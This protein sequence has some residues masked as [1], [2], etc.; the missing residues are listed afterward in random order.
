MNHPSEYSEPTDGEAIEA[1]VDSGEYDYD[2]V[3][4]CAAAGTHL[5]SVDDDGYCNVCGFQDTATAVP[6]WVNEGAPLLVH[7][8]PVPKPPIR[9][10]DHPLVGFTF[11]VVAAIVI[12]W[13]LFHWIFQTGA[14][15]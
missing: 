14:Q 9:F 13:V 15:P 2:A 12:V 4:D 8:T 7:H 6:A 3:I 5:Q 11:E 10:G 1:D